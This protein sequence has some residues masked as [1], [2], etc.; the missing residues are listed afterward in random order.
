[1]SYNFY[2][3]PLRTIII[4]SKQTTYGTINFR[5]LDLFY[6]YANHRSTIVITYIIL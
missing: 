1:M 5:A 2:V 3:L 6:S 4:D